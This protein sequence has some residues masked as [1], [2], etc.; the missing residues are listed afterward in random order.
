[1]NDFLTFGQLCS[2]IRSIF[3]CDLAVLGFSDLGSD[4][5][6][7]SSLRERLILLYRQEPEILLLI[8]NILLKIYTEGQL[9]EVPELLPE[10]PPEVPELLPAESSAALEPPVLERAARKPI[11][12]SERRRRKKKRKANRI[13]RWYEKHGI[14]WP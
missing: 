12:E 10:A 13:R 6:E 7:R 1:M 5:S 3:S 8:R 2:L 11:S 4:V 9:P 14:V